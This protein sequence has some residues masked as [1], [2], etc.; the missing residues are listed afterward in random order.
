MRP[1]DTSPTGTPFTGFE[2]NVGADFALTYNAAG[3]F[4]PHM[5]SIAAASYT[6][7]SGGMAHDVLFSSCWP[8]TMKNAMTNTFLKC[9]VDE[10]KS[11]P[12]RINGGLGGGCCVSNIIV[13]NYS[14]PK[15]SCRV[16]R[17]C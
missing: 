2:E 8:S 12:V 4:L 11:D 13:S 1:S 15:L 5:K 17:R 3:A 7:V 10:F 14:S 16:F 6:I 9:L